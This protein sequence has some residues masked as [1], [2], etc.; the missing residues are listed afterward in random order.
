MSQISNRGGVKPIWDIVPN[1]PVFYDASHK[2]EDGSASKVISEGAKGGLRT[3]VKMIKSQ[4][5]F[6]ILYKLN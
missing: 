2:K 1:F 6:V 3:P 5:S 4:D